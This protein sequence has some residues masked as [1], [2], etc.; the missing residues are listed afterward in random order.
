MCSVINTYTYEKLIRFLN[1]FPLKMNNVDV[2]IHQRI[3]L[4]VLINEIV[5]L[6]GFVCVCCFSTV[7]HWAKVR[8]VLFITVYISN[9]NFMWL[10]FFPL[11]FLIAYTQTLQFKSN[12][13]FTLA[14]IF[15]FNSTR[16]IRHN[17]YLDSSR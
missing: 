13:N 1:Y 10:Q 16:H 11:T 15:Y 2:T 12:W 8:I 6:C 5:W 4:I 17:L 3:I 14:T 7:S 9:L